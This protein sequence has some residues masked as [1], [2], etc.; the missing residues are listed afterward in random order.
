MKNFLYNL[1]VGLIARMSGPIEAGLS[2]GRARRLRRSLKECEHC[3]EGVLI[4][5]TV[6][7]SHPKSLSIG[8]NVHIG[9]DGYF[10]TDGGLEIGDNTH[11]SRRV[12]IYTSDHDWRRG[13]YLP[14]GPQRSL[15]KVTIGRNVWI[16]MN[17]CIL[18]GVSIGEGA[19]V[20][21]GAVVAADVKPLSIVGQNRFRVLGTRDADQYYELDEKRAFGG[22]S[23]YPW[24]K[25]SRTDL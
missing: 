14:Y 16:G 22:R 7:L 3:G 13:D 19:I 10:V 17:A 9:D 11:I 18:P 5:P 20:A 2:K 6:T 25:K 23:G 24:K 12:T 21:M 8:D 15:K 4:A 1:V